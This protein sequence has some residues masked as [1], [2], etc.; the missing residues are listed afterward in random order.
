MSDISERDSQKDSYTI[1]YVTTSDVDSYRR[2]L[3]NTSSRDRYYRFFNHIKFFDDAQLRRYVEPRADVVSMIAEDGSDPLGVAQAVVEGDGSAEFAVI[4]AGHARRRGVATSLF[5]RI[6]TALQ[7]RG[8]TR[9]V[10]FSLADNEPFAR[11]ATAC[12]MESEPE[13]EDGVTAWA[14][15]VTTGSLERG[16]AATGERAPIAA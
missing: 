11:F 4:I 15:D 8:I 14:L 1:R 9:L 7:A 5:G 16:A 3:D 12:G 13:D 6:I 2:I 10:A